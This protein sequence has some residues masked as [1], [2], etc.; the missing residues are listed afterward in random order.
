MSQPQ[1][2]WRN[3]RKVLIVRLRSIGDTVLATPSLIALRRFLPDAQIDVLLEDWVAPVLENFDAVDN[4]FIVKKGDTKNRLR[5]FY[6]LSQRGYDVAYNLHGGTTAGFFT[7][8][9]RAKY[10]VGFASYQ[11]KFLYNILAPNAN[12]FWRQEKSHSAE[13][14]LALLGFTGVPVDDKPKSHLTVK[15]ELENIAAEIFDKYEIPQNYEFALI[16]PAAAFE[17]KR[18]STD[19][20][21]EIVQFLYDKSIISIA[22]GTKNDLTV[23][24]ELFDKSPLQIILHNQTLPEIAALASQAKIFI[25][26]DSGIAHIAAAVKT[27]SVVIFGS[28]NVAHWR[29]WTNAP[30]EIVT[31]NLDCAP[32]AGYTC[33]K[34]DQPECIRRVPIENV[35]AAVEKVLTAT[36]SRSR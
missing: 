11:Y 2:E 7:A 28:S 34:F 32:C 25:G 8:A 15:P 20:F 21:A 3:V 18:W 26:N 31:E 13:Q 36:N 9:T 17:T 10:R 19:N 16:H 22:V 6:W 23:L 24:L 33:E 12:E 1:I 27:P 5:M 29:P 35:K 4:V 30:H 14:Q